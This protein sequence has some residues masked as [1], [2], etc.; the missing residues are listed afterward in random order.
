MVG[1]GEEVEWM[2]GLQGRG[3]CEIS[4]VTRRGVVLALLLAVLLAASGF[5]ALEERRSPD[6]TVSYP[7]GPNV[8]WCEVIRRLWVSGVKS[9]LR[10]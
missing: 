9:G 7:P 2:E 4:G 3:I 1:M 8:E 5:L 10:G 6:M